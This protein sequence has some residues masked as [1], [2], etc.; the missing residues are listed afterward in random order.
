MNPQAIDIP[1]RAPDTYDG[2][3]PK[4]LRTFFV[5]CNLVFRQNPHWFPTPE[6]K[7]NYALSFLCGTALDFIK[8][9]FDYD[10]KKEKPGWLLDWDLFREE[11]S[12]TFGPINPE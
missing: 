9:Y 12:A 10:S 4:G 5:Q 8:P 7:V 11:L 3:S 2:S 1:I 6:S